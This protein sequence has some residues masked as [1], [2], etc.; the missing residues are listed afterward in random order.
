M[1]FNGTE[2]GLVVGMRLEGAGPNGSF[3]RQG[4]GRRALEYVR[5]EEGIVPAF[6]YPDGHRWE[7]GSH[8]IDDGP[9][10][11]RAMVGEGLAIWY[12]A[13]TDVF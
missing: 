3:K 9:V 6:R 1:S 5:E 4:I 2:C 11:A 10:F 13:P 12:N 7:D 8:P